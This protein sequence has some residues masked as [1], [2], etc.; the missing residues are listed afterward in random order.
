MEQ[1]VDVSTVIINQSGTPINSLTF[2]Q[3]PSR[4]DVIAFL[5]HQIKTD[6]LPSIV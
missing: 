5:K 3:I 4:E 6:V 1:A 2:F